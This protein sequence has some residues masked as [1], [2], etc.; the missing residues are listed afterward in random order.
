MCLG[1]GALLEKLRRGICFRDVHHPGAFESL[2][3]PFWIFL[4][5]F[6]ANSYLGFNKNLLSSLG[7]DDNVYTRLFC[8]LLPASIFFAP[9]YGMSLN[10]KGF[11]FTFAITLALGLL[12]SSITLIPSLPVQMV[13]FLAFTNYRALLYSAYFTFIAHSFGS[14]TM[15]AVNAQLAALEAVLTYSIGACTEFSESWFGN[16]RGMSGLMLILLIPP[17]VMT[18]ALSWHLQKHPTGDVLA[19]D[20]A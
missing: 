6:A 16:L 5:A 17:G 15:G 19:K 13:A 2:L 20:L 1:L 10:R 14:R 4:E 8:A 12:W 18:L 7:D 9:L 3:L 11:A